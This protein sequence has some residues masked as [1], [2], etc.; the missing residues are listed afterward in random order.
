SLRMHLCHTRLRELEVLRDC[1]LEARRAD[2]TLQPYDI[3]VMAPD[4]N[5]YVPLLPAVFGTPG[6]PGGALPYH[7]S[8]VPLARTHPLLSAF[9]RLLDLP[10][11][12][13]DVAEIADLLQLP[14]VAER[15]GLD[16]AGLDAVQA[17]LQASRVA[18]GLDGEHRAR[19]GVPA[20]E[21]HTFA[22]AMDR[23]LAGVVFGQEGEERAVPL[24]DAD[25]A[26]DAIWPIAGVGGP[27]AEAVGA[28]YAL[29]CEIAQLERTAS[30]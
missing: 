20:I 17:W 27:Q 18:W 10:G 8:D 3:A 28:L 22:W 13:L 6:H 25:A 2:P 1:L 23:L 21:E 15:F 11:S 12:R 26:D 5:A 16:A 30:A 24:P 4:I 29:L 9:A 19:F 7:L 14:P